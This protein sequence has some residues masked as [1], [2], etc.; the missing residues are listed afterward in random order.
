MPFQV[1]SAGYGEDAELAKERLSHGEEIRF[2]YDPR[3]PER[4]LFA[5]RLRD[6]VPI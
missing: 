4:M 2:I 6:E 5:G 1:T 3:H